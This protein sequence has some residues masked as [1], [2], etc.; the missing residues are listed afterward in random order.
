MGN[1]SELY[2]GRKI[3]REETEGTEDG[4]REG[5]ENGRLKHRRLEDLLKNSFCFETKR[6]ICNTEAEDLRPEAGDFRTIGLPTAYS[7][8]PEWRIAIG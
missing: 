8:W 2:T 6:T 1:T 7:L 5:V 4:R 3:T